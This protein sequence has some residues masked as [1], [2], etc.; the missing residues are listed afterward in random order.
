MTQPQPPARVG[1]PVAYATVS[2]CH[3]KLFWLA[4]SEDAA[5]HYAKV[6]S[7]DF[8]GYFYVAQVDRDRRIVGL[9]SVWRDGMKCRL[10]TPFAKGCT[11]PRALELMNQ[12]HRP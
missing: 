3:N 2:A 8:H 10:L 4:R 7:Q 11:K 9:C 1:V 12:L 6:N 5:K